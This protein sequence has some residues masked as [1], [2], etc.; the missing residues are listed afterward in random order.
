MPSNIFASTGTNVSIVFLDRGNTNGKV[1]LIDASNLG[2]TVKEDKNQKNVLT[3]AEEDRIIQA[4]NEK[5]AEKDFSVVV[6]YEEIVEKN[7]SWSAGQYFEV[8]VDYE[9]ITE[10]E[11]NAKIAEHKTKLQS[12]FNKSKSLESFILEQLI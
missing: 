1:V 8:K 4:F 2:E 12:L 5:R 10:T 6:S 9:L 7:Y 11:F 3:T